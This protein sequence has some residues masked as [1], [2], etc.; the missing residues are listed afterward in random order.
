MPLVTL[1]TFPSLLKNC[2]IFA[3]ISL[4][5]GVFRP[6]T[7]NKT[8]IIIFEKNGRGTNSIWFYNL[9]A[10]GFDLNSDLR[11]PVDENDI[12]DLL[13]KY[14]DKQESSKSWN[15]TTDVIEKNN[16]DLLAKT[17]RKTESYL[18]KFPLVKFST[19]MSE[20]KDYIRI[21]DEKMY[22]RITIKLHGLGIVFR[23]KIQGKK[24][25]TKS[26]KLVKEGQ[27][28]VAELDAKLGA[29]GVIPKELEDAIVSS[30][31]WLFDLDK[32]KVLPEYFDYVIRYGPYEKLIRPS[33]KGTTNYAAPRPKS[34]LALELPLPSKEEQQ[35]ILTELKRRLEIKEKAIKTFD[36]FIQQSIVE[37]SFN[38]IRK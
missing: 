33:V 24:I 7:N 6:Y 37:P 23:D 13:S 10:D 16:Y 22:K 34:M 11:K 2:D 29:F 15:I 20:N 25:K 17:Y 35:R 9:E 21:V 30:H 5:I 4:P 27:F 1:Q 28:I 36:S 38:F 8:N 26:Q 31:Y 14:T 3:I 18:S 19:I 12:P 32:E